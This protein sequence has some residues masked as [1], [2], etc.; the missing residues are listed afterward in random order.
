MNV[1]GQNGL[2]RGKVRVIERLY[3]V[4]KDRLQGLI[5]RAAAEGILI[6]SSFHQNACDQTLPAVQYLRPKDWWLLF[7]LF[8]RVI[9]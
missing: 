1:V 9:A 8:W 2:V 4:I 6:A 7:E 3:A 5:P